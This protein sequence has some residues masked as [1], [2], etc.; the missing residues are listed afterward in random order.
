MYSH[1]Y[2]QIF[3]TCEEDVI[4]QSERV[5]VSNR[6]SRETPGAK[7]SLTAVREYVSI[8]SNMSIAK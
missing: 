7:Q 8:V 6:E 5:A 1:T 2:S 4:S 3:T